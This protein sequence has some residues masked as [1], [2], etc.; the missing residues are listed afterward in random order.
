MSRAEARPSQYNEQTTVVVDEWAVNVLLDDATQAIPAEV[1]FART[2]CGE[3]PTMF[4]SGDLPPFTASGVDP[5]MLMLLPWRTRHAGALQSSAA[6]LLSWVELYGS[7]DGIELP[8]PGLQ[9]YISRMWSWLSGKWV[10]P[11]FVDPNAAAKAAEDAATYEALF[12]DEEVPHH[13]ALAAQNAAD[14]QFGDMRA[15]VKHSHAVFLEQ[16][17]AQGAQR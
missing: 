4:E 17:R 8:S 15:G 9:E 13:A 6:V 12:G 5:S 7:D 3:P 16:R 2:K 10:N 1:A 11:N 14:K